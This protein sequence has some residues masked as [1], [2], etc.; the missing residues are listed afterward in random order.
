[1]KRPRFGLVESFILIFTLFA[2]IELFIDFNAKISAARK[3]AERLF[4]QTSKNV[5]VEFGYINN[6]V[7]MVL[8]SARSYRDA[9]MLDFT[10]P[11]SA[12]ALFI[13][14]MRQYPFITSINS[15]DA[16]GS[17]YLILRTGEE[18]K[19]R[20]KKANEKG[21]VTW[22]ILDEK[23]KV[24]S[25]ERHKDDY[26]PRKRPW[27][28]NAVSQKEIVWSDPYIFR[29]T[30]DVGITA[31]MRLNSGTGSREVVGI[32]IM[33]KDMSHLL[34]GLAA[35]VNGMAAHLIAQDCTVIAFSEA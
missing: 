14:Y 18:W 32:D 17:G 3:N 2:G 16:A 34:A 29:T 7:T 35:D 9:N 24:I 26:D 30:R 4:V 28:Q 22:L 5:K 8:K 10:N 6:A 25:T 33:L 12:N 11:W 20:I 1:M 13:T 19:N 15:G 27:Y 23:G 21:L 31:S